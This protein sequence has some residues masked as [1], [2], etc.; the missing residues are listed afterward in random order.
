MYTAIVGINVYPSSRNFKYF[1]GFG[2]PIGCPEQAKS[3]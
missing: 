2:R 3:G 1:F